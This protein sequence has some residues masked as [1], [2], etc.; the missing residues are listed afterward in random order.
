[1]QLYLNV[2]GYDVSNTIDDKLM[3]VLQSN[4]KDISYTV[5]LLNKLLLL[6][7]YRVIAL[8]WKPLKKMNYVKIQRAQREQVGEI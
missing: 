7:G 6:L 3:L 1:M 4:G 2:L 5:Y 8:A